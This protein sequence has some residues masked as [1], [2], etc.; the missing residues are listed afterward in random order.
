M[1]WSS[2]SRIASEL[3]EAMAEIIDDDTVRQTF[4]SRMIEIFEDHDC[5]TLDECCGIDGA[6]DEAWE[7]YTDI[8]ET[9]WSE[10]E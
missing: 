7:E 6:F 8:E 4:Y 1:G 10:E 2:G 3:I 5:D 9:D